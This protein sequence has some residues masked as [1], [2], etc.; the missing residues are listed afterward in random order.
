MKSNCFQNQ[1]AILSASIA[2]LAATA[3][4]DSSDPNCP[5]GAMIEFVNFS[6]ECYQISVSSAETGESFSDTVCE[7]REEVVSPGK[8]SYSVSKDGKLLS[9]GTSTLSCDETKRL[10]AGQNQPS[11]TPDNN[12]T[13]G[14]PA[15]AVQLQCG[16][17][18]PQ[19]FGQTFNT[20]ICA[21][22]VAEAQPCYGI[23]LCADGG[24]PWG[25][26]CL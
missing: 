14:K 17:W 10:E 15:G 4:C 1:I 13:S 26:R 19:G 12:N 9:S 23:G 20:S 11:N 2:L 24:L 8:Y 6:G 3:A 18:G 21:S 16:C 22:G 7:S 25:R 5:N